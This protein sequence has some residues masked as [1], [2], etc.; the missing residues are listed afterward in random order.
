MRVVFVT[1]DRV[2]AVVG[3]L[4]EPARRVVLVGIHGNEGVIYTY[5][6]AYF[7]NSVK[8][9]VR[10][11]YHQPVAVGQRV[12]LA[13]AAV[14]GVGRQRA[15]VG[16]NSRGVSKSVVGE[17]IGGAVGGNTRQPL[18]DGIVGVIHVSPVRDLRI[19]LRG[20]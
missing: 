16:G 12:E 10:I 13:V 5:I 7:R 15:V 20:G 2:V 4:V 17:G 14:V 19:A 18:R 6:I 3:D 9:V 1:R 11:F 8:S